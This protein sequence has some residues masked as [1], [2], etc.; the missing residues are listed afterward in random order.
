MVKQLN[1]VKRGRKNSI[2]LLTHTAAK[3]LPTL[4][5]PSLDS[6]LSP[7]SSSSAKVV[8]VLKLRLYNWNCYQFKENDGD[9]DDGKSLHAR[10]V[11]EDGPVENGVQRLV[12]MVVGV[13]A[14][15]GR[16]FKG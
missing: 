4:L 10:L 7:F 5:L 3:C 6:L 1:W 16:H 13:T 8:T 2:Q 14:G 12:E 15:C 11:T 9:H